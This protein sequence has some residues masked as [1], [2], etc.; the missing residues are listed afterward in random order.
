MPQKPDD[1]NRAGPGIG[2][3]LYGN[4]FE[5]QM[6]GDSDEERARKIMRAKMGLGKAHREFAGK[7]K[8]GYIKGLH[9]GAAKKNE[10][11]AFEAA[12]RYREERRKA[13]QRADREKAED[14]FIAAAKSRK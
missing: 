10:E 8:S 3:G 5:M 14:A 11:N 7:A 6:P 1:D 12:A 9:T 2:I 13:K 4:R